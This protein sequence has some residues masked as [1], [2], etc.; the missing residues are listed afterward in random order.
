MPAGHYH[1]EG[2]PPDTVRYW[3]GSQ[4]ASEPM[5]APP[6]PVVPNGGDVATMATVGKMDRFLCALLEAVLALVTLGIGWL[7]WA[8]VIVLRNEG[9]TPA[10][11]IMNQQ[12]L[13]EEDGRPAGAARMIFV[14][15]LAAGI[16]LNIAWLLFFIPALIL[17]ALVFFDDRNRT[18]WER[19][20]QTI[21]V[22][23]QPG[24]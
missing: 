4:W 18:F 13:I 3:D 17:L 24:R 7:I 6:S 2:D 8:L 5:P 21:V 9:Q 1:A 22:P 20:S 15:G 14:R 10:K 16:V 19:L 12:V 23:Y 11:K